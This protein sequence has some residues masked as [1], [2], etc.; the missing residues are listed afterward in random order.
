M[1]IST[2]NKIY[3][4]GLKI[5]MAVTFIGL[6]LMVGVATFSSTPLLPSIPVAIIVYIICCIGSVFFFKQIFNDL[7]TDEQLKETFNE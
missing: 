2:M 3:R 5:T 7:P 4:N 1:K 6:T